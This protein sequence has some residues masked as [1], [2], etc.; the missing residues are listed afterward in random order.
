MSHLSKHVPGAT[1]TMDSAEARARAALV[2]MEKREPDASKNIR[3]IGKNPDEIPESVKSLETA[4][5]Y[6]PG[7]RSE[8]RQILLR[9]AVEY[10][11]DVP[12]G[13]DREQDRVIARIG[14]RTKLMVDWMIGT[15]E[16][17][18]RPKTWMDALNP[19]Q[20]EKW[21][22]AKRKYDKSVDQ[23]NQR[24]ARARAEYDAIVREVS[25]KQAT[26]REELRDVLRDFG[27][28]EAPLLAVPSED[29]SLSKL[30]EELAILGMNFRPP[31]GNLH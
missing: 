2:E 3:A 26:A 4:D 29:R 17:Y 14:A 19:E 31:E 8:R 11:F 6:A 27:L 24:L 1:G 5:L 10:L 18:L 22:A 12:V 15:W 23:E 7:R 30:Q 13:S 21:A 16:T 20:Q 28:S 25:L 9:H